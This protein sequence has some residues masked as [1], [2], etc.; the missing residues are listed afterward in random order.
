MNDKAA[1]LLT[2]KTAVVAAAAVIVFAGVLVLEGRP[3]WCKY[4]FAVWSGAWAHCTSQN[5][6]DPYWFTH[7]LHGI[8]FYW[9]LRYA[10]PRMELSWRLVIALGIELAWELVE[11]S[12][13]VIEKYRQQTA[14]LD[15]TGDSIVNSLGDVAAAVLGFWLAS[16]IS[17]KVAVVVFVVIELV[18]LVLI[19]DNLTLNVMMLIWPSEVLKAWQLQMM[20]A[21]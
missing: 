9:V 4:G 12:P 20:G 5:L 11:N 8:I 3:G 7:V 15:Y 1:P 14:S 2:R 13:W 18:L 6:T 16:R 19:R 17:W 10:V 21:G